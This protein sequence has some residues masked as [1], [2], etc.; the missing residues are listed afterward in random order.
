MKKQ[1]QISI[2]VI[3]VIILSILYPAGNLAFAQK[4]KAVIKIGTYDS[5]IVTFAWSRSDYFKQ[6]M[7]KFNQQND[8]AEKAHD[9]ARIKEL[10]VGIISY[11]HLLHQMIFSN[12]SIGFVMAIVKD[13]LPELAKTAGVSIIIS[14][15]E[16]NFSDPSIE[17]V[18][19]T[20][21][22]TQLFHPK[23]NIDQMSKD[24]SAQQ[25]IPIDEFG[26]ETEMLD[27]YCQ[28]FGKK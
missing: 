22:I 27:G 7:I 8:S 2:S 21:Q 6:H 26:I 23:E 16:L 1:V 17:I 14:K 19:L 18:D 12:G 13:K 15:W 5:R 10:T 24:I 3:A 4:T 11:Q 25:P 28:R 9:T 20:S